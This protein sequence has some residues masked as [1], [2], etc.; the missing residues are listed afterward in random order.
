MVAL[1]L[2]KIMV[3]PKAPGDAKFKSERGESVKL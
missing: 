3:I 1:V 2:H